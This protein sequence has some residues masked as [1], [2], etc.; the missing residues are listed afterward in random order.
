LAGQ[1]ALRQIPEGD[2]SPGRRSTVG[3]IEI[4][5][6]QALHE[7]IDLNAVGSLHDVVGGT[8]FE[9]IEGHR[10]PQPVFVE[11]PPLRRAMA[12]GGWS[13]SSVRNAFSLGSSLLIQLR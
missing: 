7:G 3:H 4:G 5:R 10:Q 1:R 6:Y 12:S 2:P 9:T 13:R 8:D 11:G